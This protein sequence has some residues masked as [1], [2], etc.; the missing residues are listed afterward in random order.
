M[1]RDQKADLESLRLIWHEAS[2]ALECGREAAA[3]PPASLLAAKCGSWVNL[4]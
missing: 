3:L 2:E 1:E 4:M